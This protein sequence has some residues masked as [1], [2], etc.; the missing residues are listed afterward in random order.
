M[1]Q[2]AATSDAAGPALPRSTLVMALVIS[3]VAGAYFAATIDYRLQGDSATYAT[4]I[5]LGKFDDLTLHLGYYVVLYVMHHTAGVALGLPVHETMA[6]AN[7][8]FGALASGVGYLLGVRLLNDR[9]LALIAAVFFV[10]SGRVLMNATSSEI[11]MLQTLVVL[12]AMLLYV[13]GRPFLA[14]VMAGAG[15]LVSPLS[16]FAYLFFP[17]WSLSREEGPDWRSFGW[18][19]IGGTVVYAPYLAVWWRELLWGRRGLLRVNSLLSPSF[20]TMAMNVPKYQFKHYTTLLLLLVPAVTEWRRYR[21]LLLLTAAVSLPHV[22]IIVKLLT[23]DHTFLLNTDLLFVCW[24]AIGA[25]VL[26]RST[27]GRVV[28][29]SIVMAHAALYLMSGTVFSGE[30]HRGHAAEMREIART[31]LVGKRAMMISDWNVAVIL[32]HYGRDSVTGIAE[33]DPLFEQMYDVTARKEYGPQPSVDGMELYL[34]DTWSPSPLNQLIRSKKSLESLRQ[35]HSL[36]I[37]A[38]RQLGI[39][40]S[41]LAHLTYDLYRCQKVASRSAS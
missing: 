15:L 27:T 5:L 14:G 11:Y 3:V 20:G 36:R 16:A 4:Y 28:A 21:R 40:C 7:V 2:I 8:L 1:I 23:E 29:S 34:L 6:M 30:S 37:I 25:G 41:K 17:A 22:Y 32:T 33:N 10:A 13:H 38:E 24:L 31:Y 26:W 39:S 19:L 18:L 12:A 35:Q 9:N